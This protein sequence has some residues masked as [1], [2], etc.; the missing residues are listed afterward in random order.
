M[1]QKEAENKGQT[2]SSGGWTGQ[3][4][5]KLREGGENAEE[6]LHQATAKGAR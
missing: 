3:L 1:R 6:N 2:T 5:E 4:Q